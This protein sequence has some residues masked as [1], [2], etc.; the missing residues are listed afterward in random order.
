MQ[1]RLPIRSVAAA[2]LTVDTETGTVDVVHD[3]WNLGFLVNDNAVCRHIRLHESTRA[4]K[5]NELCPRP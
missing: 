5:E 3:D 1:R 4:S 2:L